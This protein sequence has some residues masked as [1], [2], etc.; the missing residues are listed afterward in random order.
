M[1]IIAWQ[2]G[3]FTL[4]TKELSIKSRLVG[5]AC[6]LSALFVRLPTLHSS[7]CTMRSED[8][9]V[10]DEGE[11]Q[12]A[13]AVDNMP[14]VTEKTRQMCFAG[15]REGQ[16]TSEVRRRPSLHPDL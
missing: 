15:R 10:F 7:A 12:H 3:R 11:C 8:I 14:G 2:H 5:G 6:G 16:K 4:K 9:S 1:H 13:F